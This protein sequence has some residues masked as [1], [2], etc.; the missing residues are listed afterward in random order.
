ML[1]HH[2]G[3]AAR[4]V[5]LLGQTQRGGV[6]QRSLQHPAQVDLVRS[7]VEAVDL[8]R[9]HHRFQDEGHAAA[10]A[11]LG[12]SLRVRG[13][14]LLARL[15]LLLRSQVLRVLGAHEAE[16]WAARGVLAPFYAAVHV[17]LAP[18]H[19]GAAPAADHQL[20]AGAKRRFCSRTGTDFACSRQ[21]Q[22]LRGPAPGF[23]QPG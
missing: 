2:P 16:A 21:N 7:V 10:A 9:L 18:F 6:R 15:A 5:G 23:G 14:P 20:G 13:L 1:A 8:A 11:V 3:L 17:Q 19:R 4:E 22:R 12:G